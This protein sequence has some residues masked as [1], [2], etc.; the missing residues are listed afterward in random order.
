MGAYALV[1]MGAVFAGAA[2][3]PIT[4]VVILFELTGE[5]SIILPL[6]LAIVL[7]TVTSHLLTHDTIYTLKLR[8]RGIDL[9]G[10]APGARIGTQH[11]SAVMEP[12]PSPLAA[13]TT[14]T[15]AADLLSL[16]GH[17]ALPVIDDAGGYAGVITTQ[18][19]AE[20]L[21]EQPDDAPK[22]VGRL[23]EMPAPIFADQP[24]AQA[25]HALLSAARTG[26]PVLDSAHGKPIGWLS[27]QSALRAVHPAA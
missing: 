11:V 14:L 7:A 10:A 8:R 25:L 21:A 17:G 2:R 15:D 20:A 9:E 16:S 3:A 26:V 13:S 5:Y 18:A 22:Q 4:A 23:A 24:L 12:L 27:H 1:G 6:M 19:V